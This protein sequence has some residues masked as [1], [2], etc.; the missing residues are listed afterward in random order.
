MHGLSLNIKIFSPKGS[1][2]SRR[3]VE[4]NII[5]LRGE[6]FS[7][8]TKVYA[9]SALLYA[10]LRKNPTKQGKYQFNSNIK[11]LYFHKLI[12]SAT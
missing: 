3:E 5:S 4:L 11:F 6:K 7:Y 12:C 10:C 9:I 2:I 1:N 8:S